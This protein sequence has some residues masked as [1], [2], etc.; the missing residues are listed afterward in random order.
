MRVLVLRPHDGARRTAARLVARGHQAISSP[1]METMA[2]N[3]QAPAGAFD[4]L[5]ATSAQAFGFIDADALTPFLRLPL[6][7][8]GARTA[9]AAREAGFGDI[10]SEAPDAVS[11]A[12]RIARQK[13][14]R[15]LLYL[16][17]HDRKP[18][19]EKALAAADIVIT[20]WV[21]YKARALPALR[22]D[23]ILSLRAG[24][25]DAVLH[26]SRRSAAIFCACIAQAALEDEAR[27]LLHVAISADA[28]AALQQLAPARVRI[29]AAPDEAHMLDQLG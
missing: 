28:A 4:A 23:A 7:C 2:T 16:A 27:A 15:S 6:M 21:V 8:V 25:L 20:P 1:V 12:T 5:I 14:A 26:F 17:G 10:A 11:L 24:R 18:D 29:S 9:Q 13:S 22:E 19:L 3:A